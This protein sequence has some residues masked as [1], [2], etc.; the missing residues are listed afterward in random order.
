M[1]QS[2]QCGWAKTMKKTG[3]YAALAFLRRKRVISW[4]RAALLCGILTAEMPD[5]TEAQQISSDSAKAATV[6]TFLQ[7]RLVITNAEWQYVPKTSEYQIENYSLKLDGGSFLFDQT[8]PLNTNAHVYTGRLT[9]VIWE[10]DAGELILFEPNLNP[11]NVANKVTMSAIASEQDIRE[12]INFGISDMVPGSASWDSDQNCFVA[13]PLAL[14]SMNNP[15]KS[16]LQAYDGGRSGNRILIR[17]TYSNGLA[18]TATVTTPYGGKFLIDYK[19]APDFHDGRLP[20]EITRF[21]DS[22]G[23]DRIGFH[24][25]IKTLEISTAVHM[26][27]SDLDPRKVLGDHLVSWGFWSNGVNY[28]LSM[29]AKLPSIIT[30]SSSSEFASASMISTNGRMVET[31]TSEEAQERIAAFRGKKHC[32]SLSF[33]RVA[34]LILIISTLPAIWLIGKRN[35][36]KQR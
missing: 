23:R 7:Q 17:F 27:A 1:E 15:S 30:N 22:A 16:T 14:D 26:P 25:R 18:T 24:L 21:S 36:Q 29:D 2:G 28:R 20:V 9:G 10:L 33:T 35:K 12:L 5:F 32:T 8:Y 3:H 6:E 34:I 13:E 31:L 11:A 19:Y 4:F